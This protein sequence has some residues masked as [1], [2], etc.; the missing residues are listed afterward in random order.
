VSARVLIVE[1]EVDLLPPLMFALKKEGFEVVTATTG[2]EGLRL[3]RSVR[4][5]V[6]LLDWMLPD[7]SGTEVCRALRRDPETEGLPIIMVT[8]RS[9]EIDRVVGFEVGV[10]DYVSKP[11]SVR[12]LALRIR[13]VLRRSTANRVEVGPLRLDPQEHAAQLDGVEL[14]LTPVEFRLLLQLASHPE[15]VFT[16]QALIDGVWEEDGTPDSTRAVDSVIK[17][18]RRKLGEHQG[19]IEAV[20]GMGYRW[21]TA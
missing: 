18:L 6:L 20:R 16:R 1:D 8:A 21:S 19:C 3:A 7:L 15:R 12:E 14:S 4:P 10:D 2:T 11:F 13:A 9:E 17:R 5:D